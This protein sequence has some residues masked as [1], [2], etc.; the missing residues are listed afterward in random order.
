MAAMLLVA[1][2]GLL[3]WPFGPP[4]WAFT[5]P[6]DALAAAVQFALEHPQD[7]GWRAFAGELL[8]LGGTFVAWVL[9][10]TLLALLPRKT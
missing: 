7:A 9:A 10:R 8:L 3:R 2:H 4:W 6:L 1:A 5:F